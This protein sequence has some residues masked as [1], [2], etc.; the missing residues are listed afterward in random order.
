MS[1]T[2]RAQEVLDYIKKTGHITGQQ[3]AMNLDM[4]SG[5]LT[6]RITELNR[7]G[8]TIETEIKANPATNRRYASYSLAA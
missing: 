3:A 1:I 2:P 5:S 8:Y 4:P 7:A 6:R